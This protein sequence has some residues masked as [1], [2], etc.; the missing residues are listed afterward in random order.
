MISTW[1]S[2]ENRLTSLSL[3]SS[4]NLGIFDPVVDSRKN[5]NSSKSAFR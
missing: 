5:A 4:R 2:R 3:E 1:E